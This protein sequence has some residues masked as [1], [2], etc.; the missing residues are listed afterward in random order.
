MS[1]RKRPKNRVRAIYPDSAVFFDLPENAS[2]EQLAAM[3]ASIGRGHGL[4]LRVEVAIGAEAF[5][6]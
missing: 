1:D 4:P 5:S 3:L 2:L 6:A